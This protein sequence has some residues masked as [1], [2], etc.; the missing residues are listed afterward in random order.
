MSTWQF[1]EC[2]FYGIYD[3]ILLFKHDTCTNNILQLVKGTAD[4]QE[5]D[6]IEVVLSGGHPCSSSSSPS[7]TPSFMDRVNELSHDWLL[8]PQGLAPYVS[9]MSL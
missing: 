4:I 9:D 5:G 3:K 2:G 6:L 1:P 8:P 7:C